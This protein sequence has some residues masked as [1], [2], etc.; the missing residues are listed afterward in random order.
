ME[1]GLGP[2]PTQNLNKSNFFTQIHFSNLIFL[3]KNSKFQRNFR[4]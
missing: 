3:P 2:N 4:N 1:N